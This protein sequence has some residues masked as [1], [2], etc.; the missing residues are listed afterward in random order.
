[1]VALDVVRS[2][3]EDELAALELAGL[4]VSFHEG[5]LDRNPRSASI[6]MDS[7]AG[8]GQLTVWESGATELIVD[9]IAGSEPP[10]V[11]D[12]VINDRDGFVRAVERMVEALT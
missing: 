6:A 4:R 5:P 12:R 7:D 9:L 11:D 3:Y 1:M 10:T 8:V 2:W